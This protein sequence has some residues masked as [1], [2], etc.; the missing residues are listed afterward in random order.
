MYLS[1]KKNKVIMWVF[2]CVLPILRKY[3][4]MYIN[5]Q[6]YIYTIQY[7]IHMHFLLDQN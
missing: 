4:Y 5:M 1:K 2:F 3:W 7:A 6:V